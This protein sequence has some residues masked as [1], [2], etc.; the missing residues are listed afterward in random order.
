MVGTPCRVG[1]AQRRGAEPGAERGRR[2]GGFRA[3]CRAHRRSVSAGTC[4][5]AGARPRRGLRPHLRR[6]H[7]R[8]RGPGRS[9][10]RSF[11]CDRFLQRCRPPLAA[12]LRLDA[13]QDRSIFNC[14]QGFRHVTDMM[15]DEDNHGSARGWHAGALRPR[16]PPGAGWPRLT[17][18][19][20]RPRVAPPRRPSCGPSPDSRTASVSDLA[21]R[22]LSHYSGRGAFPFRKGDPNDCSRY[23]R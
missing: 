13:F 11:R 16:R 7:L 20:P 6:F 4:C 23:R 22:P 15:L 17:R 19:C 21:E 10:V 3:P 2:R 12:R 14:Y 9:A 8:H 1:P 5:R 18:F